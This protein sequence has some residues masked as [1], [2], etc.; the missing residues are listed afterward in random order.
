MGPSESAPARAGGHE[1]RG[2]SRPGANRNDA[3]S[4]TPARQASEPS[5]LLSVVMLAVLLDLSRATVF[6]LHASGR[7]PRPVRIGG[8]RRLQWS[9]AEIEAW[10][11]AGAP[12]RDRFEVMRGRGR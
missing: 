12:G 11:E 7:L 2:D 5:L 9:R 8:L 1:P 4:V 6:K 3:Q 10:I